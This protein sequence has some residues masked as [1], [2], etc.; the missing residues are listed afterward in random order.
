MCL[1]ANVNPKLPRARSEAVSE[2]NSSIPQNKS[3]CG[4]LTMVEMYRVLEEEIDKY[5]D[6][7]TSQDKRFEYMKG[8]NKNNQRVAGLQYQ[9]QQLRLAAKADVQQ[10]RKTREHKESIT[11][12]DETFGD[13]SS[14]RVE[15]PISQT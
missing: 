13:I 5:F 10:D 2:G 3:G 8:Q 1:D 14:I 4:E 15:D 11:P 9:A 6:K 12:S 7:M